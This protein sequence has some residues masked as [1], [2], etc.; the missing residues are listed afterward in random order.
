MHV[1]KLTDE[2]VD[3]MLLETDVDGDPAV[4]N[5]SESDAIT[6]GMVFHPKTSPPRQRR[7]NSPRSRRL[8]SSWRMVISVSREGCV[9]P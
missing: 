3:E 7:W 1:E 6:T 9:C 2:D 4:Q 8:R 5:V